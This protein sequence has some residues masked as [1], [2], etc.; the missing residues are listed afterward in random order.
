MVG[1]G[2]VFGCIGHFP[3]ISYSCYLEDKNY[4]RLKVSMESAHRSWSCSVRS[5]PHSSN[6]THNA[7][8]PQI[9]CC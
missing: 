1:R 4:L 8:S 7:S 6:S 5:L 9:I 2:N 3:G